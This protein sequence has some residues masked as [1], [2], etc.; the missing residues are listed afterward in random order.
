MEAINDDGI[1]AY[2]IINQGI[3]DSTCDWRRFPFLPCFGYYPD[4][5]WI[6]SGFLCIYFSI[7]HAF[8]PSLSPKGT[9]E[10]SD[11]FPH[12]I[13]N[14]LDLNIR[15]I[16]VRLSISYI[17]FL[18]ERRKKWDHSI[19]YAWSAWHFSGSS[20]I[21]SLALNMFTILWSIGSK[22]LSTAIQKLSSVLTKTLTITSSYSSVLIILPRGSHPPRRIFHT[23]VRI[24]NT[25]SGFYILLE[26][27]K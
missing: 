7:S 12:L 14:Q 22:S 13:F 23:I 10:G 1:W 11:K 5:L 3:D 16:R 19:S 8:S 2:N 27:S 9:K 25:W 15:F 4:T 6:N 20:F 18:K 17:I 24:W 21:S 26:S